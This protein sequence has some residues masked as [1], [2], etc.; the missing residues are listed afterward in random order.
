MRG[1]KQ[2]NAGRRGS[3]TWPFP[4]SL[5]CNFAPTRSLFDPSTLDYKL[6][7]YHTNLYLS[8]KFNETTGKKI[9]F[10]IRTGN[11][12]DCLRSHHSR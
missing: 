2:Q 3:L 12:V 7:V 11:R 10:E 9:N 4:A 8:N 6:T 1:D 5:L